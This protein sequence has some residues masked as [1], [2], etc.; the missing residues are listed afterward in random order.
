MRNP[1]FYVSGKRPMPELP[2]P[3]GSFWEVCFT[4]IRMKRTVHQLSF[5]FPVYNIVHGYLQIC[6]HYMSKSEWN[7]YHLILI[8][9]SFLD[10]CM[11]AQLIGVMYKTLL[12]TEIISTSIWIRALISD[13]I[14][15]DQCDVIHPKLGYDVKKSYFEN[16]SE[17]SWKIVY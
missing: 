14:H 7:P 11:G 9:N 16:K 4:V 1:Q 15:Q 8:I 6:R 5:P 2:L 13:Y 3:L 17:Y 10:S 12:L